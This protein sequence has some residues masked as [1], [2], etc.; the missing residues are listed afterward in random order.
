MTTPTHESANM[1]NIKFDCSH[2]GQHIVCDAAAA[3]QETAYPSCEGDVTVPRLP[4]P[5]SS[6]RSGSLLSFQLDSPDMPPVIAGGM[7][8]FLVFG[9]LALLLAPVLLMFLVDE[10]EK[11]VLTY[12]FA[13]AMLAW[14]ILALVTAWGM[15]NRKPWSQPLGVVVAIMLLCPLLA[16]VAAP[17]GLLGGILIAMAGILIVPG[18]GMLISLGKPDWKRWY[19]GQSDGQR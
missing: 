7:K 17:P 2:C 6:K 1:G 13:A 12:L 18:I 10:K 5:I 15:K 8:A 16:F 19:A 4:P 14:G 3:D 9:V 11:G